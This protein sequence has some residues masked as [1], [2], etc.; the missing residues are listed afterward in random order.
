MPDTN[1]SPAV[2]QALPEQQLAL[3]RDLCRER[4]DKVLAR[5]LPEYSRNRLQ[6]WIEQGHV[7]VNGQAARIRM[8]VGPGDQI[9]IWPQP[10][11]EDEAP[12]AEPVDFSVI[13]ESPAW[14]VVD[15]PAGLV[16]HPGAGHWHGTLLNGLLHRYPELAALPRAGIVHRLDKDTSGLMVVARRADAVAPLSDQLRRRTMSREYQ[17]LVG[18]ALAGAGRLDWPIGRD[19]H[20][21]VRRT[22]Q[23]PLAPRAALTHYRAERQGI[24]DDR[25]VSEVVCH[26]VTGRT[27]QIRVHLARL[28]HPLLGDT[29]YR[30]WAPADA[31]RQM[32]HA[33]AL[34]FEDPVSGQGRT[35]TSPPP[36][37]Y[38]ALCD[39]VRWE[40]AS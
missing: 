13:S 33:R 25:A 24:L 27:H 34:A 1:R 3:P 30:G 8:Q 35:F 2:A 15:K 20:V 32:L 6:T 36:A 23:H 37:D 19:A 17:A 40:D 31:A 7:R 11:P 28:G 38:R 12:V 26:L 22:T 4:L 5:L 14:L 18:G 16:T 21:P 10:A 29:L 39:R 9:Q